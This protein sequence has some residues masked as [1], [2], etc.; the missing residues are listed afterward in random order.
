V[1]LEFPSHILKVEKWLMA[2][3]EK[4]LLGLG[5]GF[6]FMGRQV[7]ADRFFSQ[8]IAVAMQCGIL[9]GITALL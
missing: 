8:P 5:K 9:G 2:H 7:H 3:M 1:T 4:F 6:A